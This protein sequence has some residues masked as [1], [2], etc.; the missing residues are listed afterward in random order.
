MNIDFLIDQNL[1]TDFKKKFDKIEKT[2][3][4]EP[5]PVLKDIS[6]AIF[7]RRFTLALFEAGKRIR[8][9]KFIEREI[10]KIQKPIEIQSFKKRDE[11]LERAPSP[12]ELLPRAPAP[13][14]SL[15][16][17]PNYIDLF[18][19]TIKNFKQKTII[20]S[21]K[22]FLV[23]REIPR[24]IISHQEIVSHKKPFEMRLDKEAL[25]EALSKVKKTEF[26][27]KIPKPLTFKSS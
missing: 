19:K 4:K 9:Q 2:I 17:I 11:F 7:L 5:K 18:K 16:N 3:Q 27:P 22:P 13:R 20:K 26:L 21:P 6:K 24:E 12:Q 8:K 25:K 1:K 14:T 23:K 15:P 10:K